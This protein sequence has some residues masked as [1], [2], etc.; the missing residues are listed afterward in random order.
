MEHALRLTAVP[1]PRATSLRLELW[2][3]S[4]KSRLLA[5]VAG[6]PVQI[7]APD[8]TVTTYDDEAGAAD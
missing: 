6:V 1:D 3:A 8:G 5:E 2:G 7:V 4:R